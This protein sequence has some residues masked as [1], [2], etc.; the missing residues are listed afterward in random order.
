MY[1]RYE[2]IMCMRE[3]YVNLMIYVEEIFLN[4]PHFQP[5]NVMI[6]AKSL[7]LVL[8]EDN[9]AGYVK[10]VLPECD[11]LGIRA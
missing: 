8:F 1:T 2:Y 11:K 5:M 7:V 3:V 6:N 10:G 9:D 4:F